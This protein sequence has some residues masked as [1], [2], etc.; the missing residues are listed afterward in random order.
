MSVQLKPLNE[1]VIV[2]VGAS[3]GIGRETALEAA[4]RGAQ[5]V[6]AARD[7]EGL[8]SLVAEIIQAGGEASYIV[9]DV[10]DFQQ[11]KAIGEFAENAYH[12]IDTWVNLAAVSLYARL[13]DTT[14]Q[15]FERVIDV[16]LMGQVY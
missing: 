3:S 14:P 7:E 12:H 9:A 1:Q 16:N 8:L 2:L 15:E 11:V 6:V 4:R 13:Q 10:S 5:V